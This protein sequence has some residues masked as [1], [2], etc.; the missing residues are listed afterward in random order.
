MK[1]NLAV[2]RFVTKCLCVI[3]IMA[4][5]LFSLPTTTYASTTITIGTTNIGETF[6]GIGGVAS[7]G[8][9]KLLAEYPVNQRD[10]IID[11]LFKPNF[12]AS[13]HH[14]KVEIGSDA[15]STAGTEPSHMRSET[16]FDI[17]RGFGLWIAQQAKAENSD[18]ML[19]AIR[20]GTPAWIT[21]DTQKYLYYKNFLLGA[22]QT[23]GLEF[24]YLGP[25]E[26]EG[27]F[28]RDWVVNTLRPGLDSD[29]YS[30]VLLTAADST[31]NW[32]IATMVS[33]D[34]SLKNALYAIN[35]H[36]RQDSPTE[37]KTC[38]IPIWDSEDLAPYTH[39]FSHSLDVAY[40]IIKSYT[41]GRMVK[42]IM[43][44]VVEAVYNSTP[45]T[46]KSILTADT[47]WTGHYT[48][49]PSLWVIA[50]FTQF[51]QPGWIF[52]DDGCAHGTDS[53][54]WTLKS[55]TTDDYSIIIL[56]RGT[57]SDSY[58]FNISSSLSTDDIKV[59]GSNE[60][61]QFF[62]L[63]DI[64]PSNGTFNITIPAGSIY[65][66]TTTTGQTK[67]QA[68]YAIP[69]SQDF[70][71]PYTDDF[72]SYS[73]GKQPL[74]TVDQSGAFEIAEETGGNQVLRQVINTTTKPVNWERRDTPSP[75]TLL[76]GMEW[77]NY[78][79]SAKVLLE[80][81]GDQD[82]YVMIGGRT[83][84]APTGNVPAECYNLRIFYDGSWQLRKAALVLDS[85]TLASFSPDTW[86]TA[87]LRFEDDNIKAY[88]DATEI[89]S[90]TDDEIPSGNIIL[91]SGYYEAR[92]DDLSITE[93]SSLI[94]T[95]CI[96]YGD[97]DEKLQYI[98][99]WDEY[100]NN[101][102]NYTRTLQSSNGTDNY[103]EF[104][105]NGTQVSILGMITTDS[106]KADVYLDGVYQ[107]TVDTYSNPTKYRKALYSAYDL[108]SG[109]HILKLIING[110]K[111]SSSTGTNIYI[112]AVEVVGGTG[113]IDLVHS[114]MSTATSAESDILEYDCESE[115]AGNP[116]G[117]W[118]VTNAT[119][120]SCEI[121]S[122]SGETNKS[123]KLIDSNTS[124]ATNVYKTFSEETENITIEF[125]YNT[126][127]TGK[128]SRLYLYDGTTKVIELYDSN[129]NG[130]CY[131]N[132]SGSDIKID[133][134]SADTWYT[135]R[136]EIDI[137]SNLF[138]VYL[139]GELKNTGC[140]FRRSA[141]GIE[142]IAFE[143]GGS[144]TGTSYF[145]DVYVGVN[146]LVDEGFDGITTGEEPASWLVSEGSST[147][148][149]V[150][151][152]PSSSD[153]SAMLYDNNTSDNVEISK[154]FAKQD[155]IIVAEYK[156]KD[157]GAGTWSRFILRNGSTDGVAI[158][159]SDID[160]FCY[161]DC[162]GDDIKLI[163]VT[164]NTWYTV[165][166]VADPST[167]RFDIYIDGQLEAAGCSF[168][169]VV[170]GIDEVYISSGQSFTGTTYFD[171]ISI[172]KGQ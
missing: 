9:T 70:S 48:V 95:S 5:V 109:N 167:D 64:T 76:G 144:F 41:S 32:D 164:A 77:T 16:D 8:M 134:I 21:N 111:N 69:S 33:N 137:Q 78:E 42:Y 71:L 53:A 83:N 80:S 3:M 68:T 29:G 37:A 156:F 35:M 38:G 154:P 116:P 114:A 74:Y 128:W 130:L 136:L 133:D 58:T 50:Q 88:V 145:D 34:A 161:R 120:T 67:G 153:K 139:N 131:R 19:D 57:E 158:Y 90:V 168:R 1:K 110:D 150:E 143:S 4:L 124:G 61:S 81:N 47:P 135:V 171:D 11:F 122:V 159:N 99:T 36:Y 123:I 2:K 97:T 55:P 27:G 169:N 91:G 94:P 138:S 56:N 12:G 14:L 132:T 141:S 84:M 26:N 43:H 129:V 28:D 108:S 92:F 115:T 72:E 127:A 6:E 140:T 166:I 103:L 172:K 155:G 73:E 113:L 106:G 13:L 163:D 112:D 96:R 66:L 162:F 49:E 98:G 170:S 7:N 15:N 65:T 63:S 104:A 44:P 39:K 10:D 100:E 107:E 45:Y 51:I 30:D 86:Y 93:I 46:H 147:S 60:S 105:F 125:R 20:W 62:Q 25:D 151:E 75:Y 89:S 31:V 165:K 102:K 121:G 160:G 40:R 87:K 149:S 59:W 118:T 142:A 79:V 24:D 22:Y 82:G 101:A 157:S 126:E 146:D 52:L 17:T 119:N 148:V 85:G 117:G 18:I 54:Y 152:V 23:Y